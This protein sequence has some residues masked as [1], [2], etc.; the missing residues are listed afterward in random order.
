LLRTGYEQVRSVVLAL[1]GD[2]EAARQIELVVPETGVCSTDRGEAD[3]DGD[4]LACCTPAA[5][6]AGQETSCC[7]SAAEAAGR[8][9][10]CSPAQA[11]APVNVSFVG[12]GMDGAQL[13][14]RLP[15]IKAKSSG[16][17]G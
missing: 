13:V 11:A 15:G 3:E 12:V 6:A 5:A 17:C 10:C 7:G 1:T 9:A 4:A 14:E 2:W 16:C 8:A